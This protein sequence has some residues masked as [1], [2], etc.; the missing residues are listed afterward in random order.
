MMIPPRNSGNTNHDATNS[1]IVDHNGILVKPQYTYKTSTKAP[2]KWN[3]L[4]R[5][6][7]MFSKFQNL[8]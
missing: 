4:T 6:R 3:F 7:I 8:V 1:L 2:Q 5:D